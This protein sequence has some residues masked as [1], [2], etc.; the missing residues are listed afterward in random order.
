MMREAVP[1]ASW[2]GSMRAFSLRVRRGR[3]PACRGRCS[4]DGR[5]RAMDEVEIE[6]VETL[7]DRWK[8]LRQYRLRQRRRDGRQQA[9]VREVY[10]M[11]PA[12]A[13][14]PHDP[15]RGTVLLIRQFRLPALLN[16]DA[17]KLVEACA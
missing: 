2:R 12:V 1:S 17:P 9:L 13:V 15:Q 3:T 7:S 5:G 6:S 4:R 10:C 14:L 16:G 8:P 11:G